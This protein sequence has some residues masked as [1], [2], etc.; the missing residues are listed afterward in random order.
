MGPCFSH[1]PKFTVARACAL[2]KIITII[3]IIIIIIVAI[4]EYKMNYKSIT[5]VNKTL[6]SRRSEDSI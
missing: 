6:K 3:I 2:I 5:M 4:F 1:S